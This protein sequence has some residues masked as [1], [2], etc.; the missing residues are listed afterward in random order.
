MGWLPFFEPQPEVCKMLQHEYLVVLG[1]PGRGMQV[2]HRRQS[3]VCTFF[4]HCP[5][6]RVHTAIQQIGLLEK[7][8]L[9]FF[10]LGEPSMG[11]TLQ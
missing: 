10:F 8:F 9:A 7:V 1:Q 4:Y 2:L 11:K 5:S 3:P 6:Q